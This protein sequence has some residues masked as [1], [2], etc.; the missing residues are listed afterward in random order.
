MNI[1]EKLAKNAFFQLG[2][3]LTL[4]NY[5]HIWSII[6]TYHLDKNLVD[7][8][9]KYLKNLD[10]FDEYRQKLKE[11]SKKYH[12]IDINYSVCNLFISANPS[13]LSEYIN[14][15]IWGIDYKVN[16]QRE[17]Y[18]KYKLEQDGTYF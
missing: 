10:K 13:E 4:H 14:N 8:I 12:K 2:N 15:G 1:N 7:L 5:K 11:I 3:A 9:D 16:Q 17:F 6:R 18:F